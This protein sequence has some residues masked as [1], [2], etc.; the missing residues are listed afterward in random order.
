LSIP[1]SI[2]L[3]QVDSERKK[4]VGHFLFKLMAKRETSPAYLWYPKDVLSSGRISELSAAEEC[5]YRRALDRSWLD[6]GVPADPA[7]CAAQIGKN[8][9]PKA[10][11][12]IL[13]M[14]FDPKRN[15][16]SRM[17]NERQ[18]KERK[19]LNQKRKQ[20]SEAGKRGM[21]KRWEQKSK[22]DNTVITENNIPIAIPIAIPKEELREETHTDP[23]PPEWKYPMKELVDAFPDYLPDRITPSMIGFIESEVLPADRAA[24]LDTIRD[25]KQNFNPATNRYLPDKTGNLLGV[26]RKH[27]ADGE[28]NAGNKKTNTRNRSNSEDHGSTEDFLASI[29]ARPLP[30]M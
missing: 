8:C 24:W 12:K 13:Q 11:E 6:D 7:K 3:L 15:D 19:L 25:Y 23:L 1:I 14:F 18:E 16:V 10:A 21:A 29:G 28:R 27:K 30:V 4:K 17:I 9:T 5:W 2:V 20:K 26:F 22:S